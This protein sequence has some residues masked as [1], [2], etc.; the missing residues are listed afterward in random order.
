MAGDPVEP[1]YARDLA[2]MYIR[3]GETDRARSVAERARE[4]TP[5]DERL[6]R[7][8]TYVP[9]EA[10]AEAWNSAVA[11]ALD[12]NAEGLRCPVHGDGELV[13][14][15]VPAQVVG[16]DRYRLDCPMCGAEVAVSVEAPKEG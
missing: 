15:Q 12:G 4:A 10:H 3:I 8:A 7:L 14:N 6:Q 5:G 2:R 9:A 11:R 13:W 1:D 16:E